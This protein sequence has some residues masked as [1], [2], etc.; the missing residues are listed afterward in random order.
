MI[1]KSHTILYVDD[2]QKSTA[3]YTAVLNQNPRLNVPGMT[4]FELTEQSILGIM[5]K[6]G[7]LKLLGNKLPDSATA[8][9]GLRAEIYLMVDNPEEYHQRVLNLGAQN[10]SDLAER[11]WGDRVAYCLDPDGYILA[12]AVNLGNPI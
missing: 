3:F 2:Q 9:G 12:F 4:E 1:L 10:L 6:S 7:I 5:P 11:D 8:T